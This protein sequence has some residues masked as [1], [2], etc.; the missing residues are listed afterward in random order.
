MKCKVCGNDLKEGQKFCDKCGTKVED[1]VIIVTEQSEEN[2]VADQIPGDNSDSQDKSLKKIQSRIGFKTMLVV[3]FVAFFF[4]FCT[5]SCGS[6][7]ITSPSGYQMVSDFGLSKNQLD[8]LELK[9]V[10]VVDTVICFVIIIMVLGVITSGPIKNTLQAILAFILMIAFKESERF[11]KLSSVGM[12][13]DFEFGY[14]LA[15]IAFL[16]AAAAFIWAPIL[17]KKKSRAPS[18][19]EGIDAGLSGILIL[20]IIAAV[21]TNSG[22]LKGMYAAI[23]DRTESGGSLSNAE[24]MFENSDLNQDEYDKV[25]SDITDETDINRQTPEDSAQSFESQTY[26]DSSA[27]DMQEEYIL[28]YSDS[29][30][31]TEEEIASFSKEQLRLARNEIYAKHGRKFE[32]E[33]LNQYFSS[34]PWY[35]G[36]LSQEEF[37]DS[38]LNEYERANL[39]MIKGVEQPT[40][41]DDALSETEPPYSDSVVNLSD[42]VNTYWESNDGS[43][44]LVK[45][46]QGKVYV[47]IQNGGMTYKGMENNHD[48][49]ESAGL[50]VE[51][52]ALPDSD[53]DDTIYVSW[54]ELAS[55]D[56]PLVEGIETTL[57]DGEYFYW[58]MYNGE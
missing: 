32:T 53:I 22:M 52:E 34:Q 4:P 35:H 47:I 12:R 23:Y 56:V 14:Y 55:L 45:E 29:R 41:S 3:A 58:G 9:A 51:F 54:R 24:S 20:I 49:T 13:V 15:T 27:E 25:F 8:T 43:E 16:L 40:A 18:A 57:F 5:V 10:D 19:Y 6:E 31:I 46:E 26:A 48:A 50:Y 11:E 37:D 33:D 30:Y 1:N 44:M 2:I 39:D 28:P 38:V 21:V 17:M 42:V 36:Y 7:K